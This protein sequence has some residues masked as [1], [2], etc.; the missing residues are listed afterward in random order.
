MG[1]KEQVLFC[2]CHLSIEDSPE[3]L[4]DLFRSKAFFEFQH[5]SKRPQCRKVNT[6]VPSFLYGIAHVAL[7]VRKMNT[8]WL[9]TK[10]G[11]IGATPNPKAEQEKT[12]GKSNTT[13]PSNK[14]SRGRFSEE[15]RP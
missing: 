6:Y 13:H 10:A 12:V 5:F 4:N 9:P 7:I 15:E 1:K 3:T 2:H 14:P 11:V 8:E